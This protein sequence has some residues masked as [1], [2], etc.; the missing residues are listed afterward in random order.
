MPTPNTTKKKN[1]DEMRID[2]W[3]KAARIFKTREE[4]SQACQRG[5]VKVNEQKVKASK[6]IKVGDVIVARLS[7]SY[8][9]LEIKEIP[10]RGL[11]VKDAMLTYHETTPEIPPETKELMKMMKAA[12]KHQP[13]PEKGRPTKKKRRELDRWRGNE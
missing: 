9:T 8:R 4:A 1:Y 5:R 3:L 7:G 11:S 2:K 6:V 10:I 12:E 13:Q